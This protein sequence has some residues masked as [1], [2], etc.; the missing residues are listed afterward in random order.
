[1]KIAI[2]TVE[3]CR[4]ALDASLLARAGL[5]NRAASGLLRWPG[6]NSVSFS[7]SPAG[8]GRCLL[9]IAYSVT[10]CGECFNFQIPMSL[11]LGQVR[12][13]LFDCRCG[14]R[15]STRLVIIG[16]RIVCRLCGPLR[17]ESQRYSHARW[18]AG[19]R[20]AAGGVQ[21]LSEGDL[22]ALLFF[23]DSGR[24]RRS[25]QQPTIELDRSGDRS[26]GR[27]NNMA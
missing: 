11:Q 15:P 7:T 2:G 16:G 17:H 27:S 12:R 26:E 23:D 8:S 13:W 18:R 10:S 14:G 24:S 9:Q 1:M 22:I 4:H 20:L 19:R 5:L 21:A 3:S 6:G 25:S